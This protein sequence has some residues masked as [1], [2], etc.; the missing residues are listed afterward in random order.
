[1]S[2]DIK[3]LVDELNDDDSSEAL[4]GKFIKGESAT[5][6][7]L[8][9]ILNLE[10]NTTMIPTVERA[11][12]ELVKADSYDEKDDEID[13]G[14]QEVFDAAM[15]AFENAQNEENITQARGPAASPAEVGNMFLNTA[16]NAMKAKSQVKMHKDKMDVTAN[17]NAGPKTLNQNIILADRNDL[18]KELM[19]G[20]TDDK[21]EESTD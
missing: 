15:T 10:P 18:L 11:P 1:M 17:K 7:P 5:S 20:K 19:S 8:E 21:G 4:E 2:K 13:K 3:D 6:H 14:I 16:L 12:S 9:E